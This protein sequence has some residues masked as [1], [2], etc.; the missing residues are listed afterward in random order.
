MVD[1]DNSKPNLIIFGFGGHARAVADVALANGS[2]ELIF[3]DVNARANEKFLRY[4]VVD[5]WEDALPAGWQ[6]F[7][8][9][10]DASARSAH[11]ELFRARGWP[12]ATLVA[13][14]ATIGAGAQ[15]AAGS[16]VARHAHVGPMATIGVGCIINTG[17]VIEHECAIGEF[18]HVSVN[19]TVAGRTKIGRLCMIGAGATVIDSL[20]IADQ[21]VVGA[22]AVVHRSIREP[23][24]YVG[25]PFRKLDR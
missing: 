2:D 3:V 7:S 11:L 17:A 19:S 4:P 1:E 24:V 13:S 8:A 25:N 9:A 16:L 18:T 23:G 6:V 15:V 20:E 12:L 5:T 22:G 14:S 21:V 10:G